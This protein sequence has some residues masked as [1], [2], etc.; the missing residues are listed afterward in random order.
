MGWL[1]WMWG[2]LVTGQTAWPV[3]FRLQ[4]VALRGA[5]GFSEWP[6]GLPPVW[7][8]G[9]APSGVVPVHRL[10]QTVSDLRGA[11]LPGTFAEKPHPSS[12][13][14]GALAPDSATS[15]VSLG[16]PHPMGAGQGPSLG[17]VGA[18]TYKPLSNPLE[19]TTGQKQQ[20]LSVPDR[21]HQ[22]A[23]GGVSFLLEFLAPPLA[24]LFS[25]RAVCLCPEPGGSLAFRGQ[26]NSSGQ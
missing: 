12:C 19:R 2:V 6:E 25:P 20:G 17:R 22:G 10:S 11:V 8:W 15:D 14:L 5:S 13:R 9:G 18:L 7:G 23:A 4:L 26:A 21:L 16:F 3:G 1:G 24:P